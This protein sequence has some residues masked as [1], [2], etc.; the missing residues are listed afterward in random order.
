MIHD[1]AVAQEAKSVDQRV[2]AFNKG[3]SDR[4]LVVGN[5]V[6]MRVPGLHGALQASW[7]GPY[8]VNEKGVKSHIQGVERRR[9]P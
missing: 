6:L 7:E 1:I 3:K 2:I 5:R 8:V 9:S 4:E